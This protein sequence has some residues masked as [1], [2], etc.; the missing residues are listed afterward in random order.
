MKDRMQ[1]TSAFA[2]DCPQKDRSETE[3]FHDDDSR[4]EMFLYGGVQ[5]FMWMTEDRSATL[6]DVCQSKNI[7]EVSFDREHL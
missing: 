2:N 6:V 7:V 5:T 1:K 4:H 3:W